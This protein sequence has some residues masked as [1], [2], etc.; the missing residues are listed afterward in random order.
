MQNAH[1]N[2]QITGLREVSEF[3][4]QSQSRKGENV[5]S[6]WAALEDTGNHQQHLVKKLRISECVAYPKMHFT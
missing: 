1:L 6:L 4:Q 2:V 5:V 3:T